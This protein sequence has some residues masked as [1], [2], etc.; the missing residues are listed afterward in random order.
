MRGH[1]LLTGERLVLLVD[2]HVAVTGLACLHV[3]ESLVDLVERP[4][5][6]PRLDVV[7][8]SDLEHLTDDVGRANEA[9]GQV[10]VLE[11][12]SAEG[13]RGHSLLRE[14]NLHD[15]D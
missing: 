5:L 13:R 9:A 14:T 7:L 11:D 8:G 1:D 15:E 6:D 10:D 2:E 3:D 12:H 4:L